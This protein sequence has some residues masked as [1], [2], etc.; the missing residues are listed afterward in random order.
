MT[1]NCLK[2][3]QEYLI[4]NCNQL[5]DGGLLRYQFGSERGNQ[6][7]DFDFFMIQL[8]LFLWSSFKYLWIIEASD[9]QEF[10]QS[11]LDFECLLSQS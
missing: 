4:Q 1:K 3:I 5:S 10:G 9:N 6:L 11:S 2:I 8:W 7:L